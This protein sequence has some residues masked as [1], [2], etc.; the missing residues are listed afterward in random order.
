MPKNIK[1]LI[2]LNRALLERSEKLFSKPYHVLICN[3]EFVVHPGVFSP[4][5][6]DGTEFF[7]ER[8]PYREGE[9]FLEIGCGIGATAVFAALRGAKEVL[10]VDINPLA[11]TNTRENARIHG[12]SGIVT[13]RVSDVFSNVPGRKY[14]T[15]YW[16]MPFLEVPNN[17]RYRSMLE[18]SLF[19]P[20]YRL[21]E[22]FIL[23]SPQFLTPKGRVLI[24]F[25]NIGNTRRLQS[26][27]NRAGFNTCRQISA[28]TSLIEAGPRS[29]LL[30]FVLLQ[31]R[32]R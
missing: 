25:G 29:S 7:A 13:T 8:L 15:I 1:N 4:A 17:Y 3:H 27:A 2:A 12:V 16:N 6:A 30:K 20:G 28:R 32:F 19:D 10:A 9:V 11:V 23:E 22:R 24:G 21:N 26:N 5:Y 14:D 18:R 31:L